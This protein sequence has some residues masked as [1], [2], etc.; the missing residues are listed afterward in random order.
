MTLTHSE[1]PASSNF[2]S[3][4]WSIYHDASRQLVYLSQIA[5][6]FQAAVENIPDV[7]EA[8]ESLSNLPP[9]SAVSTEDCRI[10]GALRRN[11]S[12]LELHRDGEIIPLE[13]RATPIFRRR[14]K[15]YLC[16]QCF[17]LTSFSANNL[18]KP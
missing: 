17:F 16:H 1:K 5:K 13:V 2:R 7:R 14:R 18:K 8:V 15:H 12:G 3:H 6:R 4:T 10:P 11:C 9:K